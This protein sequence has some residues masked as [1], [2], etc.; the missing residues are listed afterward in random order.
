VSL[1]DIVRNTSP[2][3]ET[4]EQSKPASGSTLLFAGG[5]RS[6]EYAKGMEPNCGGAVSL[7][8][9][10][11]SIATFGDWDVGATR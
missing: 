1:G 4:D 8:F 9:Y 6:E 2:T 3:G 11:R 5:L 7:Q 10:A